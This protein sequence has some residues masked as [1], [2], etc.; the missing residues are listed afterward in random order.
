MD[1]M[2][3][4]GTPKVPDFFFRLPKGEIFFPTHV[5][6][7]KVLMEN[8]NMGEK[9]ETNLYSLTR[10]PSR[11]LAAGP[12]I[13]HL[14]LVAWGR[15]GLGGDGPLCP[16]LAHPPNPL[17]RDRVPSAWVSSAMG[18]KSHRGPVLQPH[19]VSNTAW[20]QQCNWEEIVD[21]RRASLSYVGDNGE[22]PMLAPRKT[23]WP[24]GKIL[25]KIF[26]PH[27]SGPKMLKFEWRVQMFLLFSLWGPLGLG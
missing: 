25:W 7:L 17:L 10:P 11:P 12:S 2:W 16:T 26:A 22:L 23:F 24:L 4:H 5:S 9:H 18:P 19:R 6:R 13:C 27:V 1:Y 15:G 21:T 20:G 3:E 8:S 14:S